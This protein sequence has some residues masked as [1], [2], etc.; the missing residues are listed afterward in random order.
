MNDHTQHYRRVVIEVLHAEVPEA[1]AE[2][3]SKFQTGNE[4]L[5]D[6]QTRERCQLLASELESRNRPRGF[7]ADLLSAKLHLA[8]SLGWMFFR[9]KNYSTWRP[10]FAEFQDFFRLS[11]R[12]GRPGHAS[13]EGGTGEA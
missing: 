6:N 11:G 9:Q 8:A 7:T 13:K 10:P 12:R 2:P 3:L 4:S 1:P 5:E